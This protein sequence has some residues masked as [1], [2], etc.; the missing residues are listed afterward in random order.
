VNLIPYNPVPGLPYRTPSPSTTARF[1]ALLTQ[2]GITVAIR[3]RKGDRIRAAC[4]QLRR[5]N[6]SDNGAQ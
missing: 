1:A 3:H 2:S 4:G 6:G 5:G